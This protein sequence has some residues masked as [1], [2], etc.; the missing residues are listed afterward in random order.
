[1][2]DADRLLASRSESTHGV[3]TTAHAEDAGLNERARRVRLDGGRWVAVHHGV[4]R[5]A[6]APLSWRGSLLAACWAGGTR[7]A[8][9]HRSAAKLWGLPGGRADLAEIV[10]PRWRRAR[11]ERLRVHETKAL[12]AI[13]LTEVDRIPVTTVERTLL[14]LGAVRSPRTVEMAFESALRRELV[15]IGSLRGLLHRV[16]RQGRN[17]VGVL[18]AI[19]DERDPDHAPTESEMETRVLQVLRANGLPKPV[20]QHDIRDALGHFIARVDFAIVEWMIALE[21][22]SIEWHTGK[23]ALF[24]DNPRRRRIQS[25]GWKPLGITIDDLRDGG[26]SLCTE[27]RANAQLAS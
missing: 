20:P 15:T 12:R 11:H 4:Y 16:G 3:F 23:A 26:L 18:R 10:C 22:E 21:Y 8:A 13:D 17:G 25:A 6:G 5:L 27:I 9:S 7:A 19:L 1:M 2:S 14:D 24:R